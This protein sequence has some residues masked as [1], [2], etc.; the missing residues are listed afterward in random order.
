MVSRTNRAR[1][2]V[3]VR[4]VAL[5][6]ATGAMSVV[7]AGCGVTD[8][9]SPRRTVTVYV[10]PTGSPSTPAQA[11]AV[12]T[13][14]AQSPAPTSQVP[15]SLAAGRQRG[16]PHSF[17]EAQQRIAGARVAGGTAAAFQSPSGNIF[18][19]A[20]RGPS[21]LAACDVE[22]GRIT[23]PVPSICAADGPQDI[24]R[25]ELSDKGA[26]PVCNSDTI[27]Q[28]GAPTLAYGSRTDPALGSVACLSEETGMTCVDAAS[29]H[30]FFLARDTFVTF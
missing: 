23:P 2:V 19:V 4:I 28:S 27:R 25:I 10:D 11:T 5:V 15:I 9:P 18:C 14:V 30:G 12:P 17:A 7:L 26:R 13:S 16:A 20:G 1:H 3:L 8:I 29:H 22:E 21:R 6:G 24:G